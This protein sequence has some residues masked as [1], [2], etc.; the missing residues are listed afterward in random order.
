MHINEQE[1]LDQ[2]AYLNL[3]QRRGRRSD[4]LNS[5]V[6]SDYF[7]DVLFVKKALKVF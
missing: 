3:K 5:F 7:L 6:A 1:E 2:T 4:K